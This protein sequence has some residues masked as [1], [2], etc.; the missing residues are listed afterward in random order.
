V[1]WSLWL[2]LVAAGSLISFTP[3]AGAINTMATSLGSGW[4]RS[5]WGILG[6]QVALVTHIAVVAAGVGVVVSGN[7]VLFDA[8]RYVGAAYLLWLGVRQWRLAP[9][10]RGPLPVDDGGP[11]LREPAGPMFR[12]GVLVNLTNPKAIVFFLAFMPQFI[13]PD[14]PLLIQY[15]VLAATV[16]VI[17]VLV[18][19]FFFAAAAKGL[20]RLTRSPAGQ[21]TVNRVFGSLYVVVAVLLAVAH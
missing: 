6:Q 11:P 9:D 1:S 15:V 21:R 19:W 4:T 13:D 5:I 20:R 17:D 16:V 3:G 14:R 10:P 2:T 7:P 8:V 18:M 12:R